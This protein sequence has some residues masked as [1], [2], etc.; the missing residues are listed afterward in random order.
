M[1]DCK[2]WPPTTGSE[3]WWC[4]LLYLLKTKQVSR[5]RSHWPTNHLCRCPQ[6]RFWLKG[7]WASVLGGL[8]G[9][10]PWTQ[11]CLVSRT[12]LR[13][14]KGPTWRATKPFF[15]VFREVALNV[16]LDTT[17]L[18]LW[19]SPSPSPTE[20]RGIG[21]TSRRLRHT[22]DH[23]F[24]LVYLLPKSCVRW[25]RTL[26]CDRLQYLCF[27]T[28]LFLGREKRL[29]FYSGIQHLYECNCLCLMDLPT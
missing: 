1:L 12:F 24:E 23:C 17:K 3:W 14:L 9:S 16:S 20:W 4:L 6:H 22:L 15:E 25:P 19:W 18:T 10:S 7:R 13:W 28:S 26:G 2:T 21:C 29:N 27:A 5:S 11:Q 8:P